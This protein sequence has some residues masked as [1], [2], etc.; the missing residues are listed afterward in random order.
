[1]IILIRIQAQ[2]ETISDE[3]LEEIEKYMLKCFNDEFRRKSETTPIFEAKKYSFE[4]VSQKY[5][6]TIEKAKEIALEIQYRKIDKE[7]GKK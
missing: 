6:M 7:L 1:M 3:M 2:L 4:K 5:N